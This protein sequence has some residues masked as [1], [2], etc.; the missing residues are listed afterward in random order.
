MQTLHMIVHFWVQCFS[1]LASFWTR[2]LLRSTQPPSPFSW[3]VTAAI[4]VLKILLKKQRQQDISATL[5]TALTVLISILL[6]QPAPSRLIPPNGRI[7]RL[8]RFT[9][10]KYYKS[11]GRISLQIRDRKEK[12]RKCMEGKW[13]LAVHLNTWSDWKQGIEKK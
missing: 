6:P 12:K 8:T 11:V 1:H 9:S 3:W 10:S 4:Y 5:S 13:K 7:F 2:A